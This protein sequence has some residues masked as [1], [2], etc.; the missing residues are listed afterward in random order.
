VREC[1]IGVESVASMVGSFSI[2][3]GS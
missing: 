3:G 1:G 2:G